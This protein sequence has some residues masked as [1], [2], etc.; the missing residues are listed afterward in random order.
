MK[1][2]TP[3]FLRNKSVDEVH[4]QMILN[5]PADLDVSEG[6]HEW[7]M[8][9]PSAIGLARMYQFILPEVIRLIFPSWS[10]G[11]YLD[12]HARNC[13]LYRRPA[14]YAVG[15]LDI[16]GKENTVIPAGSR[17]STASTNSETSVDY[18]TLEEVLIP[19]EG[20]LEVKVR[21][22]KAGTAGNTSENTVIFVSSGL[23]GIDSVTN[24][25]A[26]TGGTERESDTSL[27]TR[28]EEYAASQGESFVGNPSDYKRWA[29]SVP[30]VGEVLVI[31]AEDDS[32]LVTMI[33]TDANGAPATQEL[34]EAVYN[35]IM[36]P[37]EPDLRLTHPN[38]RLAVEAPTT[39]ALCVQ[40]TVEL[41]NGYQIDVV[42]AAFK[43]ALDRQYLAVAME[44]KEIKYTRIARVLSG[45]PGVNDYTDLKIGVS[46]NGAVVYD[47]K[48]IPIGKTELPTVALSNLTLTSGVV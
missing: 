30:G 4:N 14:T 48:N 13:G 3:P 23:R 20:K 12:A 32:G 11:E 5:L 37:D 21:C 39:L 33:I 38:A 1:Y 41:M 43:E 34:C 35:Y 26:I 9:R 16:T 18:E 25:M 7:N 15:T 22:V 36:R 10:Y 45:I 31:P 46:G 44:E 29:K 28:V 2:V 24:P 42:T 17:F 8:T 6:S 19:A 40:A 47:S 27:I